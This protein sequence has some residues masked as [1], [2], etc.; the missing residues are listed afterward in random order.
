MS[1]RVWAVHSM[2][3]L[4]FKRALGIFLVQPLHFTDEKL[5]FKD[6]RSPAENKWG[7]CAS[8]LTSCSEQRSPMKTEII[9]SLPWR[10]CRR[11]WRKVVFLGCLTEYLFFPQD[12]SRKGF[13]DIVSYLFISCRMLRAL[14]VNPLTAM[15]REVTATASPSH[16]VLSWARCLLY[17]I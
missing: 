2:G 10:I 4:P 8:S 1:L 12:W 15:I 17:I 11:R 3:P 7:C 13:E 9:T 6:S 5:R 14:K 16:H